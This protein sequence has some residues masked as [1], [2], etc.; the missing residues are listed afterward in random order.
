MGRKG[1]CLGV[2]FL[3]FEVSFKQLNLRSDPHKVE[4]LLVGS[5]LP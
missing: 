5:A 1:C 2:A 4:G 3:A